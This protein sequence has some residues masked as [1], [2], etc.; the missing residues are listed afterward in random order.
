[1]PCPR[2]DTGP[3]DRQAVQAGTR[4]VRRT[5][6]GIK[7]NGVPRSTLARSRHTAKQPADSQPLLHWRAGASQSGREIA[8]Y[9]WQTPLTTC[10][11]W[12][13]FDLGRE[14]KL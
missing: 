14:K 3:V 4:R 6:K 10:R 7:V 11:G 8:Y 2:E 9:A 12:E 1:V 5:D 13:K